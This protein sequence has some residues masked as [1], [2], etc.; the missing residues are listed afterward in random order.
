VELAPGYGRYLEQT[1]REM[2]IFRLSRRSEHLR[3]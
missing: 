2:P 3:S 1:D